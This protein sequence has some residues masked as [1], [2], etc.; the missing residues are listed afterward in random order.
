VIGSREA[1][2][3]TW[4][5]PIDAAM[6]A[7]SS[8]VLS[9]VM[10]DDGAAYWLE[11]RPAEEG[12]TVVVTGDPFS[13]PRDV[14][15]AGFDVRTMAH[16][17]GGGAAWVHHGTVFF[18]NFADQRLYRQDAGGD[19]VAITPDTGGLQR[20]ADGRLTPDGRWWIGVRERHDLGPAVEDVVNELVAVAT[21]G[22][23]EPRVVAA[24]HDF[25]S[26]LRIGPD[27]RAVC[28]LA[29]D[30]PWMPWDGNRLYVGRLGEDGSIDDAEPVAGRDGEESIWQ[31]LWAPS[32]DLV[33]AS[34]RSGWW[35]LERVR[36]GERTSLHPHDAEFGY[37]QWAFGER[38][39]G[40]LADGRVAC[41]YDRGGFTHLGILDPE[42]GELLD[43]D[44]PFDSLASGPSL[45]ADGSTILFVAASS[46]L[47]S[48]VVWLDFTS[49][50]VEV[51]RSSSRVSI[52]DAYLGSPEAIEFPSERGRT[53]HAFFYPPANP[54][55]RAPDGERPP[56]ILM[57][58]GGPTANVSA[59]L[60][61]RTRYWTSR[62]FAVVDVNYGGSTGYGRAYRRLLNGNWGVVDLQDCVAATAYLAGRGDVDGDRLLVRGG[63][64]GGWVVMCALTFTDAFAAGA[65]YYGIADLEPFATGETHKFESKYEHTMVGPW[66]EAADVY[67]ARSPI[68]SIERLTTP[69]LV[70]QG[71]ED[72]VV[73]PSQAELIV[74][75][76]EKNGVPYA[77]LLF[78]GEGH[79]FRK[80]EAL[81][82]SREAELSFYAQILGF[83]PAGDIPKLE[84]ENL[85][86]G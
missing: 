67:R 57:A 64:A 29:W 12:R 69:T 20:F 77:Y 8:V 72:K 50:S 65:T 84:V 61:L 80:A 2:Y 13:D 47:P 14:T 17:Y 39:F 59:A 85:R 6:V 33:F 48:S 18:S 44:V 10:L 54:E 35:N 15:P 37:P 27:G 46:S 73:P 86:A 83:E 9:E 32:G 60:D 66:P 58:H 78:A 51:L 19:P 40:F 52:D 36:D 56:L 75:A 43:V 23:R 82:R 21:D 3:G 1:L 25:Y 5:S 31:P 11:L 62:G 22:S 71:T 55:F 7:T 16:E 42:T 70:L 26:D 38:S 79:G 45:V 49:R 28:F 24:G 53:A 41:V 74:G 68:N 76:L 30:L 81:V 34:D 63:S 4:S